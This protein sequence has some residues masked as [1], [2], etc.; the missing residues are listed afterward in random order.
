MKI[1]FWFFVNPVELLHYCQVVSGVSGKVGEV[2][3]EGD[4]DIISYPLPSVQYTVLTNYQCPSLSR[5]KNWGWAQPNDH[6]STLTATGGFGSILIKL[7]TEL[8][9]RWPSL[10]NFSITQFA[11]F[12]TCLLLF[13]NLFKNIYF[14]YLFLAV[15]G[16]CCCV[17]AFSSCG[18]RGLLFVVVCGLLTAVASLVVEHGL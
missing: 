5:I 16:L 3:P 2:N 4:G 8:L 15:L 17:W 13:F 10:A 9:C 1:S 12:K 18:E 14:I 6:S 11:K 7:L